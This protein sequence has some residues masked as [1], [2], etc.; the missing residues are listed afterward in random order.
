MDCLTL[1]PVAAASLLKAPEPIPNR[2]FHYSSGLIKLGQVDSGM[3][4]LNAA[5]SVEGTIEIVK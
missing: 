5:G 2:D 1:S 3:E 4:E